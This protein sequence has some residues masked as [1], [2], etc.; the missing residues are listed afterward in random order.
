MFARRIST[1]GLVVTMLVVGT[2]GIASGGVP[3]KINYQGLLTDN[4]TGGPLVGE[5]ELMFRIYDDPIGGSV[6]WDEGQTLIADSAGVISAVLGGFTP[7]DISFDDAAWLEVEVEGQILLPR[8]EIVSVPYAFH[9]V[10]ADSLGGLGADEYVVKGDI[11]SVTGDMIRDAIITDD[12]ISPDADINPAKI[13]GTAWTSENDGHDSGLNAD[14]VDSLHA[15][16]FASSGHIHDDRYYL[17]EELTEPAIINAPENPVDWT[18]LKGVPDGLADGVDDVGG[19]GDGHSLDAADGSPVDAVYVDADGDVGIGTTI[20]VEKLDVAGDINLSGDLSMQGTRVVSISGTDNILVGDGAGAN[21]TG[22]YVTALGDSAGADNQGNLNTFIGFMAGMD[23]TTGEQNVFLGHLAGIGNATGESNTHLGAFA[24]HLS[25]GSSNTFVG[26]GAG[27]NADGEENTFLG[28]YAGNSNTTGTGNVFLGYGAGFNEMGSDKLYIANGPDPAD[29]LIYGDFSNGRVG[30]GVPNPTLGRLEVLG[31]SE[32][33]TYSSSQTGAGVVGFSQDGDGLMGISNNG[34]AG[35]FVGDVYISADLGVGK[36]AADAML[37]VAGTIN[38]DSLYKIGGNPVLGVPYMVS[39]YVGIDAGGNWTMGGESVTCVGYAAGDNNIGSYNTFVGTRAG[40]D[41]VGGV[42]N[43]FV[44][45]MAGV[46]ITGGDYNTFIGQNT[47]AIMA[48]GSHNTFLG[49]E[50]G[51]WNDGHRNTFVGWGTG[52]TNYTGSDN[53]FIG[54]EAGHNEKGSDKLYIANGRDTSEVLIHGDFSTGKV[55]LAMMNP[56]AT[57]T[58]NENIW[59]VAPAVP[60]IFLGNTG[61][62]STIHLGSDFSNYC[63]ITWDHPDGMELL[64]S[65]QMYFR[66]DNDPTNNVVFAEDG[67][68]GIGTDSPERRLHVSSDFSN[69]GMVFIENSNTGDNEAS[70]GFKEGS[71]AD[72][73]EIWVAGVGGWGNTNDFVIGRAAVKM[74][75][76]PDGAVGI[77]TTDPGYC[78]L[79]VNGGAAGTGAW[80][81]CSDLRYKENIDGIE[82]ALDKVLSLRGVTFDWKTDEYPDKTFDDGKHYGVI[83]QEVE[84]VLPDVVFENRDGEKGVLYTELIPVLIES[85]KTQQRQIELLEARIAELE[86]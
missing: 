50:C 60:A 73:S 11:G 51:Y 84:K 1:G 45:S 15:D 79:Y 58:V 49:A 52:A 21:N 63:G 27:F 9:A 71:D 61:G 19:A 54:Y 62:S 28:A 80:G 41:N 67:D 44:G 70:I 31:G 38:A 72:G 6:L 78:M 35:S 59:G 16:A 34:R 23:H 56:S 43:T 75:I 55:G 32:A 30:L 65:G 18:K 42:R 12:D 46:S 4:A 64:S 36:E 86:R 48:T 77:G 76:T 81:V 39:T 40:Q 20:P 24:G 66:L 10:N 5:V 26:A 37:D 82:G 22:L 7:I 25:N 33:G 83:A 2:L 53:V 13:G 8:R 14:M 3:K 69:F 29:V 85:I 57:L 47:G 68:V 17:R 74:L